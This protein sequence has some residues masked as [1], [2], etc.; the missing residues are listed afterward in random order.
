MYDTEAW[1]WAVPPEKLHR[2]L[3]LIQSACAAAEWAAKDVKSLVG[4]LI[5][6]KALIPSSRFNADHIMAWLAASNTQDRVPIPAEC[7]KQLQ[8]WR[9]L[10]LTCNNRMAIPETLQISP[11]WALNVFCDAA[12]GSLDSPGRGSGGVC[13][14]IWYYHQWH[15]SINGGIKKWDGKKVSRKLTA[16]ELMGPLIFLCCSPDAFR[17][18]PV[19]FWIDNAGSVA[20]W[21]KGYSPHCSLS[22]TIVKA[23][24]TIAAA[25]GCNMTLR[26]ITRCSNTGAKLADSLSKANFA[27]FFGLADAH[28]WDL[29]QEPL[30]IPLPLL[31]WLTNPRAD[32][33][34]GATLTNHMRTHTELI[35]EY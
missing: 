28:S 35:G 11:A 12:G 15:P 31:A 32:D 14:P 17:R 22:T 23:A 20:V 7:K 13:G 18:Q 21:K 33:D 29:C 16:L 27:E 5:H 8:F 1:T 30:R 34:L 19:D 4:K 3:E 6:I 9:L 10:L 2:I 26:K 25:L 24:S